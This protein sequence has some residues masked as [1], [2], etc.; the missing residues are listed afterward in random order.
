MIALVRPLACMSPHVNLQVATC[1]KALVAFL[2]Q[3]RFFLGMGSGM[4]LQMSQ[5]DKAARTM[6]AF[7]RFVASVTSK[8]DTKFG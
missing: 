6:L 8:M 5:L 2:A 4:Y 1:S 3:V 7:V